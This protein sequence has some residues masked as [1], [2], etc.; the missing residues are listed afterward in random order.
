MRAS[1]FC[2][3]LAWS[4]FGQSTNAGQIAPRA[5]YN[6]AT[7]GIWFDRLETFV[8]VGEGDLTLLS[9]ADGNIDKPYILPQGA[10]ALEIV[11]E[12]PTSPTASDDSYM[13]WQ[14]AGLS[15]EPIVEPVFAGY[16]V[17][18]GTAPGDLYLQAFAGRIAFPTSN[19][20]LIPE[21]SSLL[22]ILGGAEWLVLR[23]KRRDVLWE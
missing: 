15:R 5:L 21:P 17:K 19:A 7:G 18:P 13:F 12:G 16:I 23:R 22:L 11:A 14:L 20:V 6:P 4:A 1:I 2:A 3:I 9:L 8:D 10:V